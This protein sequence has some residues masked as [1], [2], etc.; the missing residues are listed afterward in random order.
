MR[1]F[2]I[3][4]L[5]H[6]GYPQPEDDWLT[7]C[8]DETCIRCGR[9]G[10]QSAPLR[11]RKSKAAHSH[12]VQL[13]WLF[14]VFL[15]SPPVLAVISGASLSGIESRPLVFHSTSAAVEERVQLTVQTVLECVETSALPTV[16]CHANNEESAFEN[17]GGP[18]RYSAS[19][20]YCGRIKF[21]PP[22]SIALRA[23]AL[24]DAPDMFLSQEWFG[25]GGIAF[26]L[27]ICSER[28]VDAFTAAHIRGVGFKQ[29]STVGV[30]TRET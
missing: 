12:V 29:V 24:A 19:D 18:K 14:D 5:G 7:E 28:L 4:A 16:T 10:S 3:H 26:R 22:T 13:N 23:A 11:I 27:T 17:F 1:W 6:H 25:S 9:R 15:A 8:F 21:H 2:A 30:S 20:P